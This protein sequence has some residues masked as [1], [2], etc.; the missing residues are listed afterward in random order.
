MTSMFASLTEQVIEKIVEDNDDKHR[1]VDEGGK[2]AV[3]WLHER[4]KTER[5]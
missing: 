4:E 2:G 1:K 5:T 3:C